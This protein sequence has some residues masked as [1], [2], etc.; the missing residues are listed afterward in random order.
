MREHLPALQVMLPLFAA[1]VA[2]LVRRR[3]LALP[4][5]IAGAWACWGVAVALLVR[6]L[7][8]GPFS[9]AMGGWAAPWG[10]ELRVDALS[11]FVLV[12]VTSIGAIVLTA[13]PASLKKELPPERDH[14]FV[15][16]YLLCLC[17]LLG[18]T[19]TGDL[20]NVFVFLEI[21]SL[22]TYALVSQGGDRRCLTATFRYLIQGTI[23]ATF[24]LIGIGF[25]YAAT[26]T[27]N[28]AD[29]AG[30]LGAVSDSRTILTAFAFLS[31]G[32]AIKMALFPLHHWLPNAY[33][34]APSMVTAFLAAT[35][36]KVSVYVFVRVVYSVYGVRFSFGGMPLEELLLPMALIGIFAASLV[37]V[38]QTDVKRLLAYSSVAQIGYMVLGISFASVSGLT[39]GLVHIFNHALMKGALFVA[40]AAIVL[41]AGSVRLEDLAGIGRRMPLTMFAWTIGGLSLIGVPLTVGF[42]SKWY[43]I[44]AALESGRW[45]VAAA[46]LASSLI[47][48][49]Y[50][51][52]V[53]EVAY[54]RE[55]PEGATR[56]EAPPSM[57]VPL[58]LLV[59]ANLYFGVRTEWT[60]GIAQRIAETLLAGSAGVGG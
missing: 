44:R 46:V 58:G 2:F 49:V 43:L 4:V 59:A 17:G 45:P 11:A 15:A 13:A 8:S 32:M 55:S 56:G 52:R 31:V 23:G 27:L 12:L 33:A 10:I 60:A 5:G 3:A 26:G 7:E 34:Y 42:I 57:L 30:R 54:F 19:I 9:Y 20:F 39:G 29:M 51:W 18:I 22:S 14:L 36:T 28:M 41:R 35:S 38:F 1:L 24:I 53:V 37:A 21:S 50:V 6:V 47:A 16:A 48:V 40:L 25:M